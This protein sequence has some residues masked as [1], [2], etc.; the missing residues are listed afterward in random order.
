MK[1]F[2]KRGH[3]ANYLNES[4]STIASGDVVISGKLVGVAQADILD[5]AE[6]AILLE[7]VFALKKATGFA[8]AQGDQVYWNTS[9]GVTKTV[10]DHLLGVAFDPALTGE[11]VVNIKLLPGGEA[12]PVAAVIAPIG[13][14]TA[15]TAIGASFA[16]LAA[17]R[18]AVNTLRTET[19]ASDTTINA[20]LDA[21]ISA[22]KAAGLMATS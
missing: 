20:K 5:A 7:G 1:D 4:G 15:F 19:L 14:P 3:T 12:A 6:G 2:V 13:A 17:A 21:V 11:T 10:T 8:I 22:L 16:D 18:T 9:T